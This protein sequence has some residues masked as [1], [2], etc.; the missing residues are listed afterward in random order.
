MYA[1]EIFDF[2]RAN[3]GCHLATTEGD[4][5]RVRGML[6]Y[7]VDEQGMVFHTGTT[8]ALWRQILSNP[9]V[10]VA[11]LDPQTHHQVRVEG[12]AEPVSDEALKAQIVRERPALQPI[13]DALGL[14]RIG[15]FRVKPL[16]AAQWSL[17]TNLQRTRWIPLG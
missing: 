10:E 3:P 8:K 7:R 5:P 1:S 16:R 4:Q 17:E 15:V 6:L 11:F 13:V 14:E 12:L 9:K 2:M